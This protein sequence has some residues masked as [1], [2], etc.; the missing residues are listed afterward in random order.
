M[1]NNQKLVDRFLTILVRDRGYSQNTIKN[2]LPELTRFLAFLGARDVRHIGEK[3]LKE[4]RE[5]IAELDCSYQT[6]NLRV[7]SVRSFCN[8]LNEHHG[9]KLQCRDTLQF[10]RNRN[11]HKELKLP[12]PEELQKFLEPTDNPMLDCFIRLLH[13]SGLR[14]A[15]AM[16][17]EIGQ[18]DTQFPIHG[19]GGKPRLIVCDDETVAQV[20]ALEVGREGK[21]FPVS[22]RYIQLKI[23]DRAKKCVVEVSA[24]TLRH[25]F[26]TRMLNLGTDTRI[27]QR[28]L[29]HSSILTTQRYTH[30]SD[31][32]LVEAY[33]KTLSTPK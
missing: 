23:Q 2:Y 25:L 7:S 10:F 19:K 4:Y 24:H 3:A 29:G 27:V 17:L 22:K 26:A 14:V 6:K 30:V 11:G 9:A 13:A 20:R 33:K 8:F 18:V 16:S 15:E 28:M 12:S 21:L 31:Q 1:E 32:M 5:K